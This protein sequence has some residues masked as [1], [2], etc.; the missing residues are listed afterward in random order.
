M[1]ARR[2]GNRDL[3][4][5]QPR[6]IAGEVVLGYTSCMRA[7]SLDLRERVLAAVDA[8]TPRP[9]I[10]TTFRVSERTIARWVVRRRTGLP[11]AGGTAPG[12]QH[13]I[14]DADL[15]ALRAQLAAAPDAT[16]AQHLAQWNVQ[17]PPVSQSALVRAMKRANWTRKKRRSTPA[18]TTRLPATPSVSA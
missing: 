6:A 9:T 14:S 3:V 13:G 7:Y 15:L 12:R 1:P 17:H 5:Q 2:A 11:I 4:P 18:S 8:G 10:A 16:L